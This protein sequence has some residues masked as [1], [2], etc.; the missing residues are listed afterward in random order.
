MFTSAGGVFDN[1]HAFVQSVTGGDNSS[2]KYE[3]I[4]NTLPLNKN[5]KNIK[6]WKNIKKHKNIGRDR[7]LVG[8][9]WLGK[10]LKLASRT[11]PKPVQWWA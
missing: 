6:H 9:K 1:R 11:H 4:M 2:V 5:R 8:V 3:I 10:T 7:R